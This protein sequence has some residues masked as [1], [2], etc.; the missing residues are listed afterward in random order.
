MIAAI[1][2]VA[3]RGWGEETPLPVDSFPGWKAWA[4]GPALPSES[5]AFTLL[6]LIG[7]LAIM[8]ITASVLAPNVLRSIERAAVR[9]EGLTLE[10]L[11]SQVKLYLRD[12]G[13]PPTNAGWSAQLVSY[14]DLSTADLTVNQRQ[15]TR[16]YV[17]DTASTPSPRA[18]I[19]SSMREGLAVP[20]YASV[21]AARF[22][23]LWQTPEGSLPSG[24][25][26]GLFSSW[27]A[28][29]GEY[30]V[31][32][33]IN[34]QSVYK[35]DFRSFTVILN[36]VSGTVSPTYQ[37]VRAAGGT[38]SGNVPMGGVPISLTMTP[39]DTLNLYM[40]PSVTLDYSFTGGT[41]NK[42]F[43]FNDGTGWIAQ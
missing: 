26:A 6:E 41:G 31:I 40:A 5:R 17:L 33:R 21:N 15:G 18:L 11:G 27:P 24:A 37:L 32:R 39:K 36:N 23:D 4:K 14:S 3:R 34:L 42:T 16:V 10:N 1:S 28:G 25:A 38:A 30:L 29:S 9:A 20:G 35:T 12:N 8:A 43:Q 13:A 7:V 2:H 22:D 19:F